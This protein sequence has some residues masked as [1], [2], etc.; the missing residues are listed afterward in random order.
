MVLKFKL[1]LFGLVMLIDMA[2]FDVQAQLEMILST[3][4]L[5]ENVFEIA[6]KSLAT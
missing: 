3:N 4:G 5:S 6:S 1:M 2:H